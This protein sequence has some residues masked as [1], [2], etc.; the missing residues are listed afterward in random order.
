MVPYIRGLT[1]RSMVLWYG[2]GRVW[3][4][5]HSGTT[6]PHQIIHDM[7]VKKVDHDNLTRSYYYYWRVTGVVSIVPVVEIET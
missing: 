3:W 5:Y 7:H 4:W 2:S 6:I 1:F